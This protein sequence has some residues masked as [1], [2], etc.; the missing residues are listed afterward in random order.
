[1]QSHQNCTEGVAADRVNVMFCI[2]TS[3]GCRFCCAG[4][5]ARLALRC[6]SEFWLSVTMATIIQRYLFKLSCLHFL[7]CFILLSFPRTVSSTLSYSHPRSSLLSSFFFL[8]ELLDTDGGRRGRKQGEAVS[9]SDTKRGKEKGQRTTDR[10]G[11]VKM[12]E[13]F[14]SCLS[15]PAS[16]PVIQSISQ[17][18][19]VFFP[20]PLDVLY[21]AAVLFQLGIDP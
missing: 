1:M 11:G 9:E 3:G 16:R 14:L 2:T 4:C 7:P 18:E 15:A 19:A 8:G 10:R 5:V 17:T 13:S 6:D 21:L 20:P 12:R